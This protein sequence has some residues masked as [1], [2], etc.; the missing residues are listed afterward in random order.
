[1][2]DVDSLI[3]SYKELVE[4]LETPDRD[5][6]VGDSKASSAL[7]TSFRKVMEDES[8][9]IKNLTVIQKLQSRANDL[10]SKAYQT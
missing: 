8:L 4:R 7:A 2:A 9:S 3:T 6:T 5:P 1:M 10:I